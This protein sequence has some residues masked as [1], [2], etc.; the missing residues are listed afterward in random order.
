MLDVSILEWRHS[1]SRPFL[2]VERQILRI[3]NI[4]LSGNTD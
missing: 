3:K 1:T 2:L 4:V